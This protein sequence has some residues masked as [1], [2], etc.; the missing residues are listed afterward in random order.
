MG[1]VQMEANR[2]PLATNSCRHK[3]YSNKLATYISIPDDVYVGIEDI[4][5]VVGILYPIHAEVNGHIDRMN[6][7][8]YSY[9]KTGVLTFCFN[10]DEKTIFHF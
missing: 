1:S 6:D 2:P 8:L 5:L 9:C 4:T 10:N 7:C 3:E